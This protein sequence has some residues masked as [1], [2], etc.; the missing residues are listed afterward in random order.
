MNSTKITNHTVYTTCGTT[1]MQCT[2]QYTTSDSIQQTINMHMI[3][4]KVS[5]QPSLY[6]DSCTF[7]TTNQLATGIIYMKC[8]LHHG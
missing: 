8:E 7:D 6:S 2:L 4:S 5:T 3:F 1:G